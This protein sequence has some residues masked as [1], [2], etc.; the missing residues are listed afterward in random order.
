MSLAKRNNGKHTDRLYSKPKRRRGST[1]LTSVSPIFAGCLEC[2]QRR[3][4]CD[5]TE[6]E[7]LKCRKKGIQCSGQGIECRFSP[8]MRKGKKAGGPKTIATG[9]A[10]AAAAAKT[11]TATASD[12]ARRSRTPS[13]AFRFVNFADGNSAQ[14]GLKEEP[15][16]PTGIPA[17]LPRNLDDGLT[18]D[19]GAESSYNQ[20][21]ALVLSGQRHSGMRTPHIPIAQTIEII[22]AQSRMLFD[23]CKLSD[24]RNTRS[25]LTTLAPV[26]KSIASKMVVI[27]FASQGYRQMI[28]PLACRDPTVS[29]AVSVVAAFH[30]AQ[31]VP[32]FQMQAEMGQQNILSKLRQS[33][34]S[35]QPTQ[36]FNLSAWATVLVLLV[37]D[38]ITGSNN[39]LYLLGLLSQLSRSCLKDPSL[40]EYERGFIIQQTCM[41]ALPLRKPAFLLHHLKSNTFLFRFELFNRKFS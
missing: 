38:T 26:S 12:A 24:S 11:T 2:R 41:Y 35:L 13:R 39:Y 1:P 23:H 9:A 28:L 20:E 17:A 40:S 16:S 10:A 36:V 6:P 25:L 30:L 22:P 29:Q 34:L 27:D 7:C 4:C 31:D 33:S 14:R 5:K 8:Y 37:G 19:N 32:S 18:D 3:V 15:A 21:T